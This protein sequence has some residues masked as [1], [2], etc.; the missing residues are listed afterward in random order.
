M[1]IVDFKMTHAF[2]VAVV[3]ILDATTKPRRLGISDPR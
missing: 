2:G 1:I 3:A